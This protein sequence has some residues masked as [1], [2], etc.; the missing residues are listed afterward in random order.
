MHRSWIACGLAL[1]TACSSSAPAPASVTSSHDERSSPVARPTASPKSLPDTPPG[2]L[3]LSW[4][5]AH[6]A[7]DEVSLAAWIE[8]SYAPKLLDRV[9]V[10]E[11]VAFYQSIVGDFGELSPTPVA[12]PESSA[13][14]LVV[15]LRPVGV[16]EPDPLT[17]LVV[18]V[19]VD[20]DDPAHLAR[21]LGLG[22]LICEDQKP[23]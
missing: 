19:E 17:T 9:D 2:R 16:L 10:G 12:V 18:E 21:A 22:A 15:H 8:L 7:G 23:R 1:A 6:N 5:A 3:A 11:H 20:P 13:R 4:L 14:R